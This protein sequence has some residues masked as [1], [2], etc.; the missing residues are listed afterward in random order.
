MEWQANFPHLYSTS[1]VKVK[2][3]Y[4]NQFGAEFDGYI[5]QTLV[6]Q[7]AI[8]L[9]TNSCILLG[10]SSSLIHVVATNKKSRFNFNGA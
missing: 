3:G 4:F 9:L 8:Q 5:S 10:V 7:E 6:S 1:Y 2:S